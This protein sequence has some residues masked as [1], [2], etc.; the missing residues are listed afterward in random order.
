MKMKKYKENILCGNQAFD[1]VFLTGI[2]DGRI[3]PIK[4][5]ER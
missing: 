5:I 4:I 2:K 1:N 3:M